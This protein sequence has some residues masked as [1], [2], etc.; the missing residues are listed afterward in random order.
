MAT[1]ADGTPVSMDGKWHVD[2]TD[3]TRTVKHL[4][5]WCPPGV[6]TRS[7]LGGNTACIGLLPDGTL[8]GYV[9]DREDR[10]AFDGLDIESQ[11]LLA[12]GYHDRIVRYLGKHEHGILLRPAEHGDIR[13]YVEKREHENGSIPPHLRL[14]WTE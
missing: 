1:F 14:R 3:P 11:I 7:F 4:E 12:L 9:P 13:I 10:R 5:H 8:L 6:E 2:P